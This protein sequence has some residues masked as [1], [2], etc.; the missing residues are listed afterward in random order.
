[1]TRADADFDESAERTWVRNVRVAALGLSDPVL[2]RLLQH[3]A[4]RSMSTTDALESALAYVDHHR[5]RATSVTEVDRAI[6]IA[7]AALGAEGREVIQ[8]P[9]RELGRRVADG[10]M[11]GNEAAAFILVHLGA[12]A[13][14]KANEVV[15]A[16][17]DERVG[18]FYDT[19]ALR[20]LLHVSSD[21]LTSM[22]KTGDLLA[23]VSAD[24]FRLYPAFQFDEV[25]Q[26]LPRLREVL[27]ELDPELVDPWGDAVWL[28][29][30]GNDLDGL[31]PASAL[32][33]GRANDVIRLAGQARFF[34]GS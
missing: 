7:D 2:S 5:Q 21:T 4:T 24:G 8:T 23:V 13:S 15:P 30:P 25:R 32:R 26:P 3:V 31:S 6:S 34:Q 19:A 12:G 17:L 33:N 27:A 11:S 20:D 22:V 28:N 10:R 29:A 18:P 9:V 16:T 1:M 14:T